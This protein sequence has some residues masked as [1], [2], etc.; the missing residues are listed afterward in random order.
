MTY[1]ALSIIVI[2]LVVLWFRKIIRKAVVQPVIDG[3]LTGP[4]LSEK[5]RYKVVIEEYGIVIGFLFGFLLGVL[6]HFLV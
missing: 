3:R 6:S 1:A 5:P 4:F 2:I